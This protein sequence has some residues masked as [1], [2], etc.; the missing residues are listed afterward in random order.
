MTKEIILNSSQSFPPAGHYSPACTANG[1]VYI[2]GQLPVTFHG[3]SLAD[4]PFDRQ[5][6]QVLENLDACLAG[7]GTS[8]SRLV[9]VRVYVTDIAQWPEFNRIYAEWIGDFRPARTVAGISEL[10][11]GSA[12]AVEAIA[13]APER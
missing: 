5:V 10:H 13:L 6:R 3:E 1:L 11:H 7:A 12:V 2:S 9:Q 8:R 4:S